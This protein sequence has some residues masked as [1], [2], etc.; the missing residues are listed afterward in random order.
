M[1]EFGESFNRD[2]GVRSTLEHNII[3]LVSGLFE[4]V[5]PTE[6]SELCQGQI[7]LI[8][9]DLLASYLSVLAS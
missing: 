9:I 2:T 6:K 8:S 1:T 5:Y 4:S 7:I 3:H